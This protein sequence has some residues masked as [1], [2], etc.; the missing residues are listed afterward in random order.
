MRPKLVFLLFI[1]ITLMAACQGEA[2]PITVSPLVTPSISGLDGQE[3]DPL[4]TQSIRERMG[5][6]LQVNPYTPFASGSQLLLYLVSSGEFE[7]AEITLDNGE[8]EQ[9]DILYAY[10]LMKNL[11]VLSVPVLIGLQLPGDRYLYFSENYALDSNGGIT[12]LDADR[13]MALAD[14]HERLPRGRIFRLLSYG[15]VTA[16]GLDWKQCPAQAFYSPEI[17]P[18]GELVEHLYPKQTETFVLRLS[19]G[20]PVNWLLV[21][22]VFKE[23][24]PLELVPGAEIDIPLAGLTPR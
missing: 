15:M 8:I 19:D 12:S 9:G 1:P 5:I 2:L 10:A 18:V 7:Q 3:L 6:F 13:Q 24:A 17:C 23:F 14:A 4:T 16:Q 22:W 21:G 11:R 20:F